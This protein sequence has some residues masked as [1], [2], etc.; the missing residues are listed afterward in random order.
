LN[1]RGASSEAAP[2]PR[3]LL[4]DYYL[5]PVQRHLAL[6]LSAPEGGVGARISASELAQWALD[7]DTERWPAPAEY[8][9][10]LE[11]LI[12]ASASFGA[13]RGVGSSNPPLALAPS[14]SMLLAGA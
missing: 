3:V 6:E 12:H 11:R 13:E 10:A 9:A 14:P 5:D 1:T 8:T 2:V 4:R 7:P